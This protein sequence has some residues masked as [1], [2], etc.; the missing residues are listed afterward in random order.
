[1]L[2]QK[3]A[4][5]SCFNICYFYS[6]GYGKLVRNPNEIR[7]GPN[8]TIDATDTVII[9]S[10]KYVFLECVA[11]GNPRPVYKWHRFQDNGTVEVTS[12]LDSRYT[13]TNGK[14]T[15]SNPIG[16]FDAGNYQC[17]AENEFGKVLGN[18]VLLSFACE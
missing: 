5:P 12:A 13:L 18:I 10:S 9:K 2:L 11:D 1:M 7:K 16:Y 6:T 17:S 4:S 3:I 15:I 8:I 14:L